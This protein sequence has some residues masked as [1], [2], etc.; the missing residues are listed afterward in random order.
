MNKSNDIFVVFDGMIGYGKSTSIRI[1]KENKNEITNYIINNSDYKTV[2]WRFKDERAS[3]SPY[4]KNLYKVLSNDKNEILG[5][6]EHQATLCK[7]EHSFI[8]T[9][10][11]DIQSF[12]Q[13]IDD[14]KEDTENLNIFILDR[15]I[16]SV[17]FFIDYYKHDGLLTE[18][19][20]KLL[21]DVINSYKEEI[22][23]S[24]KSCSRFY[25][26]RK[27][28]N[29]FINSNPDKGYENV[30]VRARDGEVMSRVYYDELLDFYNK[31]LS[32]DSL[33]GENS[34]IIYIDNSKGLT[35]LNDNVIETMKKLI[36]T[37]INK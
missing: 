24:T 36:L 18:K 14:D 17:K 23:Y 33:F 4:L 31:S 8:A 11:E 22:D 35:E 34:D 1:L 6:E 32:T 5:S 16:H 27:V 19:S 15:G 25:D 29:I 28:I 20:Y 13:F 9:M 12:K 7:I 2:T 21:T 26:D 10:G 30:K 37:T 3:I